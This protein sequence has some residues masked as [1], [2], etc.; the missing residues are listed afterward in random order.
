MAR[1]RKQL[2]IANFT[3]TFGTEKTLLDLAEEIVIPAFLEGHRRDY[4][5]GSYFF[6]NTELIDLGD[7]P[8]NPFLCIIGKF[9]KDTVLRREQRYDDELGEV[10]ADEEFLQSSP[11]ALFVLILNNHRL[12]Y[13]K[14]TSFAPNITSFQA[15]VKEFLFRQY[16]ILLRRLEGEYD[17][18]EDLEREYPPPDLRIIPLSNTSNLREFINKYQILKSVEVRLYPRN[19]NLDNDPFF[20]IMAQKRRAIHS[21]VTVFRHEN[22]GDGLDKEES[23]EQLEEVSSQANHRIKMQGEDVNGN[24]LVGTNEDIKIE[25]PVEYIPTNTIEAAHHLKTVY[26]NLIQN[27][28][29]ASDRIIDNVTNKIKQIRDN[30]LT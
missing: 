30:F 6:L 16:H 23:I 10:I 25:V 11:D 20:D 4:R 14:E 9:I 12:L 18:L 1:R 3:L 8:E 7:D 5:N 27:G 17:S 26:T 19:S 2:E 21:S 29:V 22:R 13:L 28:V 15:T 24:K